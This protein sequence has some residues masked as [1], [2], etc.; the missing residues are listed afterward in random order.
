[1]PLS[2]W[3]LSK[4]DITSIENLTYNDDYRYIYIYNTDMKIRIILKI[5][6]IRIIFSLILPIIIFILMFELIK[7][8]LYVASMFM[9]GFP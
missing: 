4:Q 7:L 9:Y 1:M 5:I 6:Y 8:W 3:I 2:L